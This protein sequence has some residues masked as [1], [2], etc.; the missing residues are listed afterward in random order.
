MNIR[1]KL[2]EGSPLL[3]SLNK[4]ENVSCFYSKTVFL[5]Q[6]L[7][8]CHAPAAVQ[9]VMILSRVTEA[10]PHPR[11][12]NGETEAGRQGLCPRL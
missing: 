12:A 1:V 6:A 8:L 3:G 2:S 4:R 5:P 11:F 7:P 10:Q 9:G